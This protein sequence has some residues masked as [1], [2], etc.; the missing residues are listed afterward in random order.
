M[1]PLGAEIPLEQ[2]RRDLGLG[3]AVGRDRAV[4]EMLGIQPL[5][6][7]QA[8]NPLSGALHPLVL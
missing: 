3:I 7:H 8:G 6:A 2:I 1:G 4:L 5:L